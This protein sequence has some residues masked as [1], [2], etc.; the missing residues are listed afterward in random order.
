MAIRLTRETRVVQSH[1]FLSLSAGGDALRLRPANEILNPVN[2]KLD[3][4]CK[5]GVSDAQDIT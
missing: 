2:Y 5:L 3:V 1:D 4:K